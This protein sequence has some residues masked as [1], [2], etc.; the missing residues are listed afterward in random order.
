MLEG[1]SLKGWDDPQ[2]VHLVV[3]T[4]RRV[5]A[6]RAAY[7]A[8]PDYADVPVQGLTSPCYAKERAATID[9]AKASSSKQIKSGTPHICGCAANPA[10]APLLAPSPG[11]GRPATHF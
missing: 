5:F 11:G 8:D 10:A 2:S 1:V 7:L 3:E 4:M 9:P 6:D